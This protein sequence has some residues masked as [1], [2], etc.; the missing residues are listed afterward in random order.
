MIALAVAC[1]S[2]LGPDGVAEAHQ[3]WEF[4]QEADLERVAPVGDCILSLA[5]G[6]GLDCAIGAPESGFQC[7]TKLPFDPEGDLVVRLDAQS[8]G[9]AAAGWME[10]VLDP[11]TQPP[12]GWPVWFE[13]YARAVEVPFPCQG[14][15]RPPLLRVRTVGPARLIVHRIEVWVRKEEPL[16]AELEV[17]GQPRILNSGFELGSFGWAPLDTT[18]PAARADR[19]PA[20]NGDWCL[21]LDTS[22]GA[23]PIRYVVRPLPS[24]RTVERIGVVTD[25]PFPL[26]PGR[27]YAATVYLRAEPEDAQVEISMTQAGGSQARARVTVGRHWRRYHVNFTAEGACGYLAIEPLNRLDNTGQRI[28][29]DSVRVA[30]QGT[31]PG[32]STPPFELAVST[33]RPGN[34]FEPERALSVDVAYV[35][36]GEPSQMPVR[37]RVTD[38]RGQTVYEGRETVSLGGQ[39]SRGS[40]ALPLDVAGNGY[41]LVSVACDSQGVRFRRDIRLAR[42]PAYPYDDS[43]FGVSWGWESDQPFELAR[44]AGIRWVRDWSIAWDVAQPRQE[45]EL[46]LLTSFAFLD[47]YRRLGLKVLECLPYPSAAWAS[48]TAKEQWERDRV[49]GF[50]GAR[51]YTPD[52]PALLTDYLGRYARLLGDRFHALEVLQ[53]PLVGGWAL[54][55]STYGPE[56]YVTLC[57]SVRET[58]AEGGWD[59][60]VIGGAYA[61]P[62]DP[63]LLPRLRTAGLDE[64][65]DAWCFHAYPGAMPAEGLLPWVGAMERFAGEEGYWATE[66]GIS[67]DDEISP[68]DDRFSRHWAGTEIQAADRTVRAAA[69]LM[70]H[71]AQRVFFTTA[72]RA[73]YGRRYGADWLFTPSGEPRIALPVLAGLTRRLG[74]APVASGAVEAEWGTAHLFETSGSAVAVLCPRYGGSAPK[75]LLADLDPPARFYDLCANEL[76]AP[77][78]GDLPFYAEMAGADSTTLR[79]ALAPAE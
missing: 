47:R 9:G 14:L 45:D 55:P 60:P 12:R 65:I 59:G 16:R 71:G 41:F 28:W 68:M 20:A 36:H 53:E 5:E 10:L 4:R 75:D 42:Y 50:V 39:G 54:P 51:A 1:L 34:V 13:P 8:V 69:L 73:R 44:R 30:E 3:S 40:V 17:G 64:T 32:D 43:P 77:P 21:L 76:E 56:D 33:G 29:V 7:S 27:R 18:I 74:P 38:L 62:W 48:S 70:T 22:P 19:G 24:V 57:S 23:R 78:S 2:L 63:S 46:D 66:L 11:A 25:R 35:S 52:D 58:M 72:S 49:F 67:G 15:E 37:V 79:E 26:A 61:Y 31:A 6:G